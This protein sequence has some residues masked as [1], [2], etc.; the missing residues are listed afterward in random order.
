M[1]ENYVN[2]LKNSTIIAGENYPHQVLIIQPFAKNKNWQYW[3][4]AFYIPDENPFQG[5][6]SYLERLHDFLSEQIKNKKTKKKNEPSKIPFLKYY[7]QI[8]SRLDMFITKVNT[9]FLNL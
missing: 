5:I 7:A 3:E 1:V 8:L 9:I 4:F 6:K 2:H